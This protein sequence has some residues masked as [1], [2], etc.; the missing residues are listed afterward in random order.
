MHAYWAL[1]LSAELLARVEQEQHHS[2]RCS[3]CQWCKSGC[4]GILKVKKPH[5]LSP[6]H[7]G[8]SSM[9]QEEPAHYP[10]DP[11]AAIPVP[12]P[13]HP[14]PCPAGHTRPREDT[15]ELRT[16]SNP[17]SWVVPRAPSCRPSHKPKAERSGQLGETGPPRTLSRRAHPPPGSKVGGGG[18]GEATSPETWMVCCL[19]SPGLPARVSDSPLPLAQEWSPFCLT[20][21]ADRQGFAFSSPTCLGGRTAPSDWPSLRC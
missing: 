15:F 10:S 7:P 3:W 21:E 11:V 9:V 19:S 13:L 14:L 8:K 16:G 6:A 4:W 5:C 1:L 2:V 18:T 12:L 20:Q 17:A